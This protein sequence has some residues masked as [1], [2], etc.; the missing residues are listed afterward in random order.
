M[1]L[2]VDREG[3]VEGALNGYGLL[4]PSIFP[5]GLAGVDPAEALPQDLDRARELLA[6]AGYE[7]GFTATLSYPT[8]SVWDIV[9][10]K[11]ASDL[12]QIGITVELEPMD[13]GLLLGR[14]W[15]ERDVAWLMCDWI[16]DYADVGN[17][18]GF[19][20]LTDDELWPWAMR[21]QEY[22]PE[23]LVEASE[24]ILTE[25]DPDKRL[26]AVKQWQYEMMDFAYAWNLYQINEHVA[27]RKEVQ[28]FGF[29]PMGYTHWGDL[30][31][32]A[33]D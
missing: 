29:L 11:V 31:I 19:F 16:P 30:W 17:W 32:E 20:G 21:C 15:E 7:D 9:A 10:A 18:S 1:G 6:E 13:F 27:M 24:T 3:I 12:A 25:S 28:G 2:A 23:A 33:S 22:L 26:E 14:A 4:P 5:I 8:S